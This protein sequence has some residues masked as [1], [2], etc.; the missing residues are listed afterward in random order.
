MTVRLL[1]ISL[2]LLSSQGFAQ[3]SDD[4]LGVWFNEE[5]SGKIEVVKQGGEYF[6]SI[7]WLEEP[8]SD[9]KPQLDKNNDDEDLRNQPIIGLQILKGFVFDDD[10]W[11]GGTI[12]DPENGTT[13]DCVI[14]K[15]G[16][17][18]K[19]RGY[20]GFSFIGRT[21]TWTKAN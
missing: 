12:Y 20:V 3:K 8:L 9:G 18:L 6:G 5:K 7:I 16:S 19:V 11:E 13:Y 10:E 2:Y 1:I 21:T 14:T 17:T 4:I 15:E